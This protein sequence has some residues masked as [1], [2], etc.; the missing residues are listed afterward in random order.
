MANPIVQ[1]YLNDPSVDITKRRKVIKAMKLGQKDTDI[2]VMLK[3][4]YPEKY[5]QFAAGSAKIEGAANFRSARD[6]AI[7]KADAIAEYPLSLTPGGKIMQA[8]GGQ[9]APLV[10]NMT[11][12]AASKAFNLLGNA[13]GYLSGPEMAMAKGI[14][15]ETGRPNI[16]YKERGI[17]GEDFKEFAQSQAQ[18]LIQET[19]ADPK[20]TA[21]KAGEFTSNIASMVPAIMTT[22]GAGNLVRSGGSA[23]A[24]KIPS[25]QTIAQKSPFV[26]NAVESI[27]SGVAGTEAAAA[28]T[29]GRGATSDEFTT[30]AIIDVAIPAIGAVKNTIKGFRAGRMGLEPTR[31]EIVK[32]AKKIGIQPKQVADIQNMNPDQIKKTFD[33]MEQAEKALVGQ[34]DKAAVETLADQFNIGL[35]KL[36]DVAKQAGKKIGKVR[37]Q[38]IK[39][40]DD[41]FNTNLLGKIPEKVKRNSFYKLAKNLYKTL[42]DQGV[43]F[44]KGVPNFGK[45]VFRGNPGD[46]K[47]IIDLLDSVKK[48]AK[49]PQKSLGEIEVKILEIDDFLNAAY[50]A[51][52]GKSTISS[53]TENVFKQAR[54]DLKNILRQ[55]DPQRA[56]AD[57]IFSDLIGLIRST[58]QKTAGTSKELKKDLLGGVNTYNIL[59]RSQGTANKD[60][61]ELIRRVVEKGNKHNISEF[62]HFLDDLNSASFADSL[63]KIDVA[64][65]PTSFAAKTAEGAQAALTGGPL[66][67]ARSVAQSVVEPLKASEIRKVKGFLDQVLTSYDKPTVISELKKGIAENSSPIIK[68]IL[69]GME[70][71]LEED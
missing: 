30:G 71:S 43:K 37:T 39:G 25:V 46:Q 70:Q 17:G 10:R 29:L 1:S 40:V 23:I 20:S 31:A 13:G 64:T 41:I 33:F 22:G 4:K 49:E 36:N 26:A 18:S 54:S 59:R 44:E 21:F 55:V 42:D 2:A 7:Q 32:Q 56:E 24:S 34:S 51:Q 66:N 15:P 47:Q 60:N 69:F 35:R 68:S 14:N 50:G 38:N 53:Q 61:L 52:P 27:L 11:T 67:A 63:Y 5:G 28:I 16:E 48:I 45:T 12:G 3:E 6:I 62:K 19:G 8:M 58:G 65:K 57:D 9:S